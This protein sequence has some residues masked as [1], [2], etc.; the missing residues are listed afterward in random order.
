MQKRV[1]LLLLSLFLAA[2]TVLA[3]GACG[4]SGFDPQSK[5]DSVRLF[6]VRA[7]K[8]YAKPGETVTLDALYTDARKDKTRLLKN[9]WIPVVCLNPRDDLYYLCFAPPDVD[10]GTRLIP[11]GID[12]SVP[13]GGAPAGPGAGVDA[14]AGAGSLLGRIPTGVDLGPFLPQ[15]TTFTF[16]MPQDVVQPRQ[17]TDPYGIAIIFNILCAG[18][19]IREEVDP[20]GGPQQVPL[21]CVDDENQKVPPSDYVIGISRVYSY[22]TRTN[23]NPVIEKIT[24]DGND[25]D[26]TKGIEVDKC[27][28]VSKRMDCPEHK[29]GVQVSDSSWEENPSET[30]SGIHEQIWVAYYGDQG[31]FDDSA[32]LLFDT[33]LGRVSDSEVKWRAP[34]DPVDGT[35]WA[36]V[37][38]NR[39]GAA[40]IVVPTHTR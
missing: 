28:G 14:G 13:E 27:T 19:V 38:D 17:G 2:G 7:D 32:R 37:H 15:G 35:I 3:I 36:V 22:T 4:A 16:T 30:A 1:L 9:Y 24:F 20:A 11:G 8:P 21:V 10:A 31:D 25:V 5:V 33:R 34:Y 26:I 40:W 12:A 23:T 6:V 39:G 18:K 29:I